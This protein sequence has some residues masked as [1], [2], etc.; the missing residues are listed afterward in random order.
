MKGKIA[1]GERSFGLVSILMICYGIACIVTFVFHVML[2]PFLVIGLFTIFA[3]IFT[4]IP[5]Q[6]ING[7]A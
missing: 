5:H 3:G 1:D 7:E 4:L 6:Y 2:F